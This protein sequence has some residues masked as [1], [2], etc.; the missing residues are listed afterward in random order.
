MLLPRAVCVGERREG[1]NGWDEW[2][3]MSNIRRKS[4][5]VDGVKFRVCAFM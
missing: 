3:G 2:A 5:A 4:P 1:I